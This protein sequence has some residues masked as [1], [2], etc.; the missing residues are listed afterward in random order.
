MTAL[1]VR[2]ASI[3][4]RRADTT[5]E[6]GAAGDG[7]E[8]RRVDAMPHATEVI[9]LQTGRDWPTRKLIADLVGRPC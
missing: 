5:Q 1:A 9:E 7:F 6:I 4:R 8:M 2:L 3:Y